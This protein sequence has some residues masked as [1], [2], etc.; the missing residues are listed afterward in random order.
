M[1]EVK[2]KR[3]RM[4]WLPSIDEILEAS[5]ALEGFC[6]AC[7]E[8]AY[9]VEPDARKYTCETC[10]EPMVY[11]PEELVLNNLYTSN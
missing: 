5:E 10:G 4:L 7:G 6:L 3:G 2:T 1:K 11:G 9:S 8:R